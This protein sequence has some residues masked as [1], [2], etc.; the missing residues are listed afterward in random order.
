MKMVCEKEREREVCFSSSSSSIA[1]N[2][3]LGEERE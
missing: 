2:V 1:Y 3:Y